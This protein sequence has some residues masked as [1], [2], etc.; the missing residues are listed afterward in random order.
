[1]LKM[2]ANSTWNSWHSETLGA[3]PRWQMFPNFSFKIFLF[4]TANCFKAEIKRLLS[5]PKSQLLKFWERRRSSVSRELNLIWRVS[6]ALL[7]FISKPGR[8]SVSK[9]TSLLDLPHC[10][11]NFRCCCNFRCS[12]NFRC[13]CNFRCT[14]KF[15]LYLWLSLYL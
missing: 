10:S 15:L 7:T 12:C 9:A 1:M 2:W 11:C 3:K 13:C 8:T 4:P 5:V 14:W 6:L